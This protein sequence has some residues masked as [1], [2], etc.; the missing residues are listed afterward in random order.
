MRLFASTCGSKSGFETE[1]QLR[2]RHQ[3]LRSKPPQ[4]EQFSKSFCFRSFWRHRWLSLRADEPLPQPN[5]IFIF[6]DDWGYGDLGIHGSTFCKTPH[7]DQ[8]AAEGHGLCK[9]Y[10]QQSSLFAQSCRRDDRAVSS[11][12][13]RAPAFPEHQSSHQSRHA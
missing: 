7:L 9:L 2:L 5:I 10:R 12:A 4:C 11:S 6:A 8:M 1:S 3:F 13:L